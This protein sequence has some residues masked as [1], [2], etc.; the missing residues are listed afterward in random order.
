MPFLLPFSQSKTSWST[1][2]ASGVAISNSSI[3]FLIS[4]ATMV[5]VASLDIS[6][7]CTVSLMELTDVA[8]TAS[9]VTATLDTGW[10]KAVVLVM[11]ATEGAFLLPHLMYCHPLLLLLKLAMLQV[12]LS[13]V[14]VQVSAYELM[15]FSFVSFENVNV[16]YSV[17]SANALAPPAN[18]ATRNNRKT[19]RVELSVAFLMIEQF[20]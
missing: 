16:L 7:A 13:M 17:S 11:E 10:S 18:N 5:S 12:N 14:A 1:L 2:A 9:I 8:V 6:P 19:C 3:P 4:L 15:P 20:L